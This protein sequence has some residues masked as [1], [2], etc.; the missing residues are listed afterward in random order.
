[1]LERPC[2]HQRN[3]KR[4]YIRLLFSWVS[5]DNYYR[6][7]AK[8]THGIAINI[9]SVRL[10]VRL[11]VK[12]VYCDKTRFGE[13]WLKCL[14]RNVVSPSSLKVEVLGFLQVYFCFEA[15][16]CQR[17]LVSKSMPNFAIFDPFPCKN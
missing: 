10:S 14:G 2:R 12:R 7:T 11:S 13:R 6:A 1:M 15:T 5:I 9:L 16:I 8:H 3:D 4:R 17:R